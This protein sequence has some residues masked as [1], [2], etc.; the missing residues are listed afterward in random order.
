MTETNK[1]KEYEEG[2]K[3]MTDLY[4]GFK[5]KHFKNIEIQD[6]MDEAVIVNLRLLTDNQRMHQ[7]K[8]KAGF[9][10]KR[11][12][13]F[14]KKKVCSKCG[15]YHDEFRNDELCL[16]RQGKDKNSNG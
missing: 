12:N 11:G 14:E 7:I 10:D 3:L 8:R 15:K 13:I 1:D 4:R 9:F 2:K 5:N 16:G 6:L